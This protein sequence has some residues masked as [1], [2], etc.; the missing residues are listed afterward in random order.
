MNKFEETMVDNSKNKIL[1]LGVI[2]TR[3]LGCGDRL[4]SQL[5]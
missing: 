4:N 5:G 2:M 1:Q 3:I